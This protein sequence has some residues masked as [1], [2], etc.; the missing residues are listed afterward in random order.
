MQ[1]DRLE[2]IWSVWRVTLSIR[3]TFFVSQRSAQR[4]P[5]SLVSGDLPRQL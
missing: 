3:Q 4:R 5:A 2:V 1:P